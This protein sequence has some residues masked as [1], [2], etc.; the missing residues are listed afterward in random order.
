MEIA[1][2]SQ[3]YLES[4]VVPDE[5]AVSA[6]TMRAAHLPKH[7][8]PSPPNLLRCEAPVRQSR[9]AALC[10]L[11]QSTGL[12]RRVNFVRRPVPAP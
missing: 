2:A 12:L 1:G 7:K 6:N 9:C 5:E 8:P 3:N 4:L 11:L 10:P